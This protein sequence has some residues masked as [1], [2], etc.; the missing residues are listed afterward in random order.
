MASDLQRLAGG[1]LA[2]GGAGLQMIGKNRMQTERDE[3]D[4]LHDENLARFKVTEAAK[5]EKGRQAFTAGESELSRE[6]TAALAE[7]KAGQVTKEIKTFNDENEPITI[8]VDANNKQIGEDRPRDFT[9]AE[10]KSRGLDEEST[11]FK[12]AYHKAAKGRVDTLFE[13]AV[14][15]IIAGNPDSM[16]AIMVTGS[17]GDPEF[18]V[19]LAR[20]EYPELA[21]KFDA[22]MMETENQMELGNK[23]TQ[24]VENAQKKI[25][26]GKAAD[27]KKEHDKVIADIIK[28]AGGKVSEKQV[29]KMMS[30]NYSEKD[31]INL[32]KVFDP[33][34]PEFKALKK[35]RPEIYEKVAEAAG[36]PGAD[37]A[38]VETIPG[39]GG[40]RV[41]VAP[42]PGADIS[43]AEVSMA[44]LLIPTPSA[45]ARTPRT[46]GKVAEQS[47][48]EKYMTGMLGSMY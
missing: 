4:R 42:V 16:N 14:M 10:L 6:A 3:A 20:K 37:E 35:S 7:T 17:L 31:I 24:A 33:N 29:K 28:V 39:A 22:L 26:V 43:A 8:L 9:A 32:V 1:L 11:K 38:K 36:K 47:Q 46:P 30:R 19:A 15:K 18:N 44:G 23:P 25:E 34:D 41:A 27:V 13:T 40:S 12:T 2:G 21:K 45:T 5:L 48:S